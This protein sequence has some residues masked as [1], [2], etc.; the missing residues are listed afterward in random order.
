VAM[1]SLGPGKVHDF[2]L[3]KLRQ[4]DLWVQGQPGNKTS[5]RSRCDGTH[6]ESGPHLLL[7]AYI[8]TLEEGRFAF[9]RRL[10][11]LAS[12]SVGI[13]FYRRRA[14]PMSLMGLS[15][16]KILGLPLTADHCWGS[17]T[18]DCKSS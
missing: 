12:T 6:L 4:G 2:N 15:K 11:W 13:Y 14:E 18:T 8:R 5:P 10:H 9:L 7:E 16:Y 3:R 1:K 17:W